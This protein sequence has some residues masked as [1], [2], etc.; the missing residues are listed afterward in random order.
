M[1]GADLLSLERQTRRKGTTP[2]FSFQWHITD[3]C[4]QRCKHCY[5]YAE[6]PERKPQRMG[7]EDMLLVLSNCLEF[8][9]IF[10]YRPV[11]Y[12]TGGDPILH[13]DYWRLL[14]KLH[15]LGI[16]FVVMGNPFH[17]DRRSCV[18]LRR[19]GCR[20]YQ[21]SLDGLEATHDALRRPGSYR[22]TLDAVAR[23]NRAHVVSVIMTTVSSVNIAELPALIDVAA[24]ARVGVYA[25][26]RY[27]STGAEGLDIVSP[28]EYRRALVEC[29]AR[30]RSLLAAG[31]R[32]AFTKKDHLWTLLD[33]EEERFSLPAMPEE[34]VGKVI[35]DGCHCGTG[36]LTIL[37]DGSVMACRRV[38]DSCVGN[39]LSDRLT[40]LWRS[41]M[42]A[43][44]HLERFERC[45]GCRLLSFCRGCPAV[46]R[47]VNG[48]FY[49]PDPQCWAVVK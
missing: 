38:P 48:S 36:H 20:Q 3:E 9:R 12:I 6:N 1:I 22:E 28:E 42:D 34:T 45:A 10:G 4:D 29:A 11:F 13:P 31:C 37:P 19:L 33:Y 39:A 2:T 44:R 32:T 27:C 41:P 7:W 16:D 43:Y 30:I 21:L 35:H 49:A 46:A 47:S 18:R 14:E 8:C 25:F 17:L 24:S 26:A 40:N 15:S 23:L 5:I